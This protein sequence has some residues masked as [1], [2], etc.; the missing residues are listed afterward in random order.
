MVK[1]NGYGLGDTLIV[2]E[3]LDLG[4]ENFGVARV[5]EA[6]RLRRM[7]P[8]KKMN[9]LVFAP[10]CASSVEEYVFN[11][12]T[13]ILGSYE[14][15]NILKRLSQEHLNKLEG[16][17]L[18]FDLGMSRLGFDLKDVD[19]VF[20]ELQKCNIR[21]DGLCGHFN[22][23][24]E[25][26]DKSSEASKNLQL[27]YELSNRFGLKSSQVH[28]PNSDALGFGPYKEGIRPGLSLYGYSD[29][30][31]MSFELMKS[32]SLRAP[33]VHTREVLKGQS[34]S[35]GRTWTSLKDTKIGVLLIGYADGIPR[36]LSGKINVF[37]E[38]ETFSQV[39]SICM[40][41]M[42]IDLGADS[43]AQLGEM[44]SL[45]GGDESVDALKHWSKT[46]GCITYE[47]LVGLGSRLH[48]R[49]I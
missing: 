27:L 30:D 10:L 34:V 40:D 4:V 36:S 19:A 18:K 45:F 46:S 20:D 33:L 38:Q 5:S 39:G 8:Q 21:I 6:L 22:N 14:D 1:A 47:L 43:N 28:L 49:V 24:L 44:F 7:F 11:N 25:I 12:L 37:K 32:L 16:V 48:R 29:S 26:D 17:H 35:Y 3:L 2:S 13:L 23:A 15:L 31:A 9:L 42:M 41:Y